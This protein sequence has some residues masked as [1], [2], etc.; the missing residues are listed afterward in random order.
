MPCPCVQDGTA[1]A[2]T[3]GQNDLLSQSC[4]S[5][6]AAGGFRMGCGTI[7]YEMNTREPRNTLV[8]AQLLPTPLSSRGASLPNSFEIF[9]TCGL[10][11]R[12][13]SGQILSGCVLVERASPKPLGERL[14]L[15]SDCPSAGRLWRLPKAASLWAK[16]EEQHLFSGQGV[17]RRCGVEVAAYK[18][19]SALQEKAGWELLLMCWT[20]ML[21]V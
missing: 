5:A 14:A 10:E 15:C 13:L 1:L 9:W 18:Q 21:S 8:I 3:A 6:K 20:G 11:A 17:P 12:M 7:P 16:A 2:D 4:H 19:A